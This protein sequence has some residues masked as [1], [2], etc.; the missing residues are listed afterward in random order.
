MLSYTI[1]NF[2]FE[3]FGVGPLP[4]NFTTFRASQEVIVLQK[5]EFR[6]GVRYFV[7]VKIGR[8]HV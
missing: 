4:V 6:D 2:L 8:A 5:N 1:A 7:F 3:F